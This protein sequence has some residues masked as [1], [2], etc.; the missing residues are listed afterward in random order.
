MFLK[1]RLPANNFLDKGNILFNEKDCHR[2]YSELL[3]TLFLI[4]KMD[5]KIIYLMDIGCRTQIIYKRLL[6]KSLRFFHFILG[7]LNI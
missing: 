1:R 2:S 7:S 6:I 3:G 4:S 5:Y